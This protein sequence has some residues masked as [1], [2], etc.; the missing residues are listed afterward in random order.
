MGF[1][2]FRPVSGKAAKVPMNM[3]WT[4][5]R[6]KMK[7]NTNNLNSMDLY[8]NSYD[9]LKISITSVSHRDMRLDMDKAYAKTFPLQGISLDYFT[10]E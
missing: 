2:I 3:K 4:D 1:L 9:P 8:E 6:K 7:V 5:V 10:L